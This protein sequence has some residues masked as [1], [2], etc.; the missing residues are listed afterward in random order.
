MT[1]SLVLAVGVG[2]F[3]AM[4]IAI[5]LLL[6]TLGGWRALAEHYRSSMP[7]SGHTW[8]FR[9][10]TMNGMAQY[11]NALTIGVNPAGLYLSILPLFRAG[12][13]PLFIPWSDVTVTSEQRF[14]ANFVV[15]QFRQAPGVALRLRE[16]LGRE[17]LETARGTSRVPST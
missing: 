11:R 1:T 16:K 9:S 10:A 3:A 14:A 15:F 7:F 4:W 12:H 5:A 2:V 8:H 13:P 6:S 17:V